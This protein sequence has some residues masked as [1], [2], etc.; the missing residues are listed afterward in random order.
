MTYISE[1]MEIKA[2][3][4]RVENEGKITIPE[5]LKVHFSLVT[6]DT[7]TLLQIGNVFLLTPKQPQ[8]PQIADKI[9][10]MMEDAGLE[11]NDLLQDLVV[12][13]TAIWEDQDK[14]A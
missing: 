10:E 4:I 7:L 3:P 1:N 13:R 8:V 5:D 6:G 9:A 11:L 2:F 12:Q 14:N